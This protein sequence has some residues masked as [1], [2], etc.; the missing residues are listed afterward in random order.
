MMMGA[1]MLVEVSIDDV[2][3]A[4]AKALNVAKEQLPK[5]IAHGFYELRRKAKI[6]LGMASR[7][8]GY[9]GSSGE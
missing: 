1:D 2:E 9:I 8:T 3:A 7:S 5:E 6:A 4:I